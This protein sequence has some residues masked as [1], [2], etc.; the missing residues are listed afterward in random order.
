[1]S[2]PKDLVGDVP[3][4]RSNRGLLWWHKSTIRLYL[5]RP[6]RQ[7]N[8]LNGVSFDSNFLHTNNDEHGSSRSPASSPN[9]GKEAVRTLPLVSPSP[10]KHAAIASLY[11]S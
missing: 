5:S 9:R 4:D 11:A 3:S 10:F 7:N 6:A 1:M 8:A 2:N